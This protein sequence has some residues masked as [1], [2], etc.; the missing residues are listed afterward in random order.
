MTGLRLVALLHLTTTKILIALLT[1]ITEL[2]LFGFQ[3]PLS[4]SVL[5][6][7]GIHYMLPNQAVGT[8]PIPLNFS[9]PIKSFSSLGK[10]NP[11]FPP[12]SPL[13]WKKSI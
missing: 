6:Q 2:V 7:H 8:N 4:V 3:I 13:F 5:S 11:A 12:P 1:L 10:K 9:L